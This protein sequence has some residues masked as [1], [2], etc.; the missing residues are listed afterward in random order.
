MKG[1]EW[2]V[3]YSGQW[4]VK[5]SLEEGQSASG[6]GFLVPKKIWKKGVVPLLPL[7]MLCLNMMARTAQAGLRQWEELALDEAHLEDGKTEREETWALHDLSELL[8]VSYLVC[9]TSELPVLR[10]NTVPYCVS[11]CDCHL[12]PKAFWVVYT[13]CPKEGHI[14]WFWF[15]SEDLSGSFPP[16]FPGFIKWVH[17]LIGHFLS[18]SS[19]GRSAL[20]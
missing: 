4:V 9:L 13:L 3:S 18:Q 6:K 11:Q 19:P 16:L 7:M 10:D 1:W 17:V 20:D 8:I 5:G 14:R 15:Y 2:P 12:Q